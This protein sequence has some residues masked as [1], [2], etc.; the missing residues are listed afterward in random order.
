MAHQYFL[1][2]CCFFWM[3]STSMIVYGLMHKLAYWKKALNLY[4]TKVFG[5]SDIDKQHSI[6]FINKHKCLKTEK[7]IYIFPTAKNNRLFFLYFLSIH[8]TIQ[9]IL[10]L[11]YNFSKRYF[12]SQ[13]LHLSGHFE[14][15]QEKNKITYILPIPT[16][17]AR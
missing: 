14:N 1:T 11:A 8:K 2:H 13:L 10:S 5:N 4:P 7:N 3:W 6:L 15:T 17:L 16:L 12:F 9:Y